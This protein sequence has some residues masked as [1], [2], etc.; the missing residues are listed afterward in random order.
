MTNHQSYLILH[1]W[2]PVHSSE[3]KTAIHIPEELLAGAAPRWHKKACR[4]LNTAPWRPVSSDFHHHWQQVHAAIWQHH[5]P[6]DTTVVTAAIDASV[7][8]VMR[9]YKCAHRKVCM[10]LQ[11]QLKSDCSMLTLWNRIWYDKWVMK[12]Y[13]TRSIYTLWHHL[14][15]KSIVL[16]TLMSCC[17]FNDANWSVYYHSYTSPYKKLSCETQSD[18]TIF[19]NSTSYQFHDQHQLPLKIRTGFY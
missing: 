6:E 16:Q 13:I 1:S 11:K 8:V 10:R 9:V 3:W 14:K 18:V 5:V 19:P 7:H 12:I 15:Y 2:Q 4:I 17:M